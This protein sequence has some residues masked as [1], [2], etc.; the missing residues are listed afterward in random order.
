MNCSSARFHANGCSE[1]D[2]M[3]YTLAKMQEAFSNQ[4]AAIGEDAAH[5]NHSGFLVVGTLHAM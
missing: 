1:I 5:Y 3:N 2:F 4:E